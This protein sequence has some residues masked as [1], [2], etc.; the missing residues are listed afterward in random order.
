MN[1]RQ[2]LKGAAAVTGAA[3]F[4]VPGGQ[5]RYLLKTLGVPHNPEAAKAVEVANM[6]QARFKNTQARA[7]VECARALN[8]STR[9]TAASFWEVGE[10][11]RIKFL[12]D[13]YPT[14]ET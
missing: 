13:N 8:I 12:V 6:W 9:A 10:G 4:V 11:D 2:F 3:A 1:R 7:E 14:T 5:E